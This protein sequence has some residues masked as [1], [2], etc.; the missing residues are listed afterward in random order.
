MPAE[1]I[2]DPTKEP[3]LE[4]VAEQP[5]M[6]TTALSKLSTTTIATQEEEDG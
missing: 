2:A 1:S 3:E 6:L 5:K 4:K